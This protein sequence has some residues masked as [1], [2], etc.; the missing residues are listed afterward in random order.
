MRR[1]QRIK[2]HSQGLDNKVKA[3]LPE[4]QYPVAKCRAYGKT[5]WNPYLESKEDNE[6]VLS[7]ITDQG[8]FSMRE[9]KDTNRTPKLT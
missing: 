1:S 7:K 4:S 6:I 3:T 2:R 9:G 8:H 5:G